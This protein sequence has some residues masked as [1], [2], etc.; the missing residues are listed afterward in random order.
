[1][2]GV[3]NP[4]IVRS[5]EQAALSG[6]S[7]YYTGRECHSGHCSER[8]VSNKQ[9]V[10]CNAIKAKARARRNGKIDPSY[11]MYRSVQR[12]SGQCLMGRHSP[13]EALGCP[14][15]VLS[16]HVAQQFTKGMSWKNYGHWEVDHIRPLSA[17]NDLDELIE[18]CNYRNVQ[19]LWKRANRVKGVG[20]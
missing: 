18:L 4:F 16:N 8:Y 5:R 11:R 14:Q 17:A 1:M 13:R 19:P 7:R 12:R 20:E 6:L 3:S 2:C 10:L 9:C 15:G